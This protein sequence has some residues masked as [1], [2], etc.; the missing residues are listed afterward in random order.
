MPDS[1]LESKRIV[2]GVSGGIAAYKVADLASK[3]VQAGALVDVIMTAG[4]QRF[5]APLTFQAIT[6]RPVR[7]DIF[8]DWLGE[9]TGHVGLAHNADLLAIAPATAN[10]IARLA[11]GLS[12]DLLCAVYL[13]TRAPVLLVPA[14]ESGMY[15]HPATQA[16]L[17]TLKERGA[18]VMQ[19]GEGHL[20]SGATG[21]GRLPEVPQIL[22]AIRRTLG[23]KGV[24][25]GRRVVVTAGGTQEPL[26][27]VRYVGNRSS[28][29]MGYAIA[30]AAFYSGADV[31]LISGPVSL[32]PPYGISL[33]RVGSAREMEQ[34]VREAVQG[35]DA[36]VMAAAVADYAPR[37][38][39]DQKIKKTGETLNIELARNPDILGNLAGVDLLR[40]VRV[41]FAA[42]T[43]QLLENAR[44]KLEKKKLDMIVANDAVS[45]IGQEESKLTLLYRDGSTEELDSLPKEES[46][47]IIVERLSRLMRS[48]VAAQD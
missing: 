5:V 14:M 21:V 20:A 48:Q 32:A 12:D 29:R 26:D 35:A 33:V 41:G 6:K 31:T 15:L 11:L 19:P 4:A 37:Q 28:G 42:E 3:L 9:D 45:S 43:E 7:T 18:T 24:L 38:V 27:P 22:S 23:M 36:L 46:A 16:H 25:A 30:E 10:T 40:L 34:A 17:A 13:S 47:A 1:S 39:S 2:L 44:G 8:S